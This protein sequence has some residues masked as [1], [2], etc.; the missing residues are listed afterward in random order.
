MT[1]IVVGVDGSESSVAALR[2]A[3]RLASALGHEVEAVAC[4]EY[5][6]MYTGF[7]ASGME[8]YEEASQEVLTDSIARA[9]GP[10]RPDNVAA[11]L[12]HGPMPATLINASKDAAMLVLGRH[13]SGG[14]G[15]LRLGSVSSACVAHAHC[16]VLVV[17]PPSA[18]PG[19]HEEAQQRAAEG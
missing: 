14:L 2:H 4:W 11:L 12:L 18:D 13:G 10:G 5:P 6:R 3:Q 16:P 8:G 15:G 1:K 19:L 7:P 17:P 9:F